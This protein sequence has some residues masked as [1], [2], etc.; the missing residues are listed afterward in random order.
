MGLVLP[1]EVVCASIPADISEGVKVRRDAW[2][3][4][5]AVS[6]VKVSDWEV[7]NC[8]DDGDV[9]KHKKSC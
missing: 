9:K 8:N 7:T 2:N 3:S 1:R 5:T 6:R 4:L